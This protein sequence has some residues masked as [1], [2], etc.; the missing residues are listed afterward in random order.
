MLRL[1]DYLESGNSYKVRLLLTQLEI[2]FER[3]ELDILR[4]ETRTPD[5]LAK[6]RNGRIPVR[7]ILSPSGLALRSPPP[8]A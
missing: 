2:P 7:A 4:G 6:N 8:E 5:F 3:I 1:Y